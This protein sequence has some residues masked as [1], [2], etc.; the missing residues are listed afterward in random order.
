MPLP[1]AKFT[2]LLQSRR[3]AY[4][5]SGANADE[6][7]AAWTRDGGRTRRSTIFGNHVV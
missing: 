5:A 2:E 7:L 1:F 3:P 4:V 6:V